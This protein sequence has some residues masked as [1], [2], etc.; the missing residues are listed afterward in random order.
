M[1][2]ILRRN[3]VDRVLWSDITV[4]NLAFSGSSLAIGLSSALVARLISHAI[5]HRMR[6]R[7]R[8]SLPAQ[9]VDD[10]DGAL[11]IWLIFTGVFI[12]LIHLPPLGVYLDVARQV[13]TIA[14]IAIVIFASIRLQG[15]IL[16]GY[17]R[18]V[19]RRTG[20][21]K[22]WNSL[23]PMVRRIVSIVLLAIGTLI[24]LDQLGVSIAPMVAGLGITGLA[25]ALALQG[26]LTNFFA[27]VNVL[28]DGSIRVGDFIEL[29][30]GTRGVVD[31]IGW[32]TTRIRMLAD[33]M[34]LIPNSRLA[35]NITTNY[36]YPGDEMSVYVE[37]GAGYS[38]DLDEVERI[39]VEIAKQ[40]LSETEG[41][42]ITYQPSIWYT[43]FGESNINFWVVM[44]AHSYL[45][46]WLVKHNFIK[47]V[48]RRYR[49]ENIE[50]SFPA[51]TVYMRGE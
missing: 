25:V 15:H 37:L 45:D 11:A 14:S 39:T 28:T 36:N 35:D 31:Q 6:A 50:I 18:Q 43:D 30:G 34:V 2:P 3:A 13:Y 27:G 51:R 32:R 9:L 5:K 21:T 44:R 10:V 4:A 42:V 22:V 8:S 19:G 29:E 24:I 48:R 40:V 1:T 38:S 46:S 41:S 7:K 20:Q 16:R 26:T 12:G 23:I 47:A 49:E 17:G 33:N